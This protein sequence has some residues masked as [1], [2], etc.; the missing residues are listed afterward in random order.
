MKDNEQTYANELAQRLG[1]FK[2]AAKW[3]DFMVLLRNLD[4][5][6]KKYALP[7]VPLKKLLFKRLN[8]CLNPALP[9]GVHNKA[10]ET[11]KLI[12]ETISGEKLV[13][14]FNFLTLGLF[15]FSIHCRILVIDTFLNIVRDH[16]IPLGRRIERYCSSVL[17]GILPPLEFES[18]EYY[19]K[20]LDILAAYKAHNAP[21]VFYSSIWDVFLRDERLRI[22][23]INFILS[24]PRDDA[25]RC[26]EKLAVKALCAGLKSQDTLVVRGCLDLLAFV[27]PSK[28]HVKDE[29]PLYSLTE[30]SLKLFHKRDLSL[31]KRIYN[32]L[33]LADTFTED[34]VG[35]LSRT[36]YR[37][38]ARKSTMEIHNFFRILIT[39][40]DKGKVC[41]RIL[42]GL[43]LDALLCLEE[44]KN[45]GDLRMRQNLFG[46][47]G[48]DGIVDIDKVVE[49]FLAMDLDNIWKVFYLRLEEKIDVENRERPPDM[50]SGCEMSASHVSISLVPNEEGCAP[51]SEDKN[52]KQS[53]RKRSRQRKKRG[54]RKPK[55]QRTS[56]HSNKNM[57]A[58]KILQLIVFAVN[59]YNIADEEVFKCHLPFLTYLVLSNFRLVEE[60]VLFSFL[61]F[62]L[63]AMKF[64]EERAEFTDGLGELIDKFYA[65]ENVGI[66]AQTSPIILYAIAD[67]IGSLIKYNMEMSIP[68]IRKFIQ[69][70]GID[71]LNP[72]FIHKYYRL[73]LSQSSRTIESCLWIYQLVECN[74]LDPKKIFDVLWERFRAAGGG[75]GMEHELE[76]IEHEDEAPPE[77]EEDAKVEGRAVSVCDDREFLT[78]LLCKYNTVF[79]NSFERFML[80]KMAENQIEEICSFLLHKIS[81]SR[82]D[83]SFLELYYVVNGKLGLGDP[84][85]VKFTTSIVFLDD[86]FLFLLKKL[87]DSD[88]HANSY[89][90]INSPD[91]NKILGVLTCLENLLKLSTKF[92]MMLCESKAHVSSATFAPGM[93]LFPNQ[94]LYR[95]L[96]YLFIHRDSG[97]NKEISVHISKVLRYLVEYR[98]VDSVILNSTDLDK[99]IEVLKNDRDYA[100]IVLNVF[101]LIKA[102]GNGT[103]ISSFCTILDQQCSYYLNFLEFIYSLPDR[104]QRK[105]LLDTLYSLKN[106]SYALMITYE[107][108]DNLLLKRETGH[109]LSKLVDVGMKFIFEFFSSQFY[110]PEEASILKPE[111]NLS[112]YNESDASFIP[113]SRRSLETPAKAIGTRARRASIRMNLIKLAAAKSLARLFFSK[114]P[115]KF[116]EILLSSHP[117]SNFLEEIEFKEE[118]YI[119]ILRN[120]SSDPSK[121]FSFLGEFNRYVDKQELGSIFTKAKDIFEQIS[122]YRASSG[123]ASLQYTLPVLLA[124]DLAKTEPDLV[125]AIVSNAVYYVQKR[126]DPKYWNNESSYK[127]EIE[128]LWD[129]ISFR[130]E[131]KLLDIAPSLVGVIFTLTALKNKA[132]RKI[133]IEFLLK[134]SS[135]GLD[136]PHWKNEFMD[137]FNRADFFSYSLCEKSHLLQE[138]MV[139]DVT[140]ITSHLNNLETGFF[141]S[142]T[143]AANHKASELKRISFMVF[144]SP[145]GHFTAFAMK[146][147]EKIT[148]LISYPSLRVKREVFFLAKILFLKIPHDKLIYLYPLLFSEIGMLADKAL[149]DDLSLFSEVMKLL[150]VIFLLNT[151]QLSEIRSI[152]LDPRICTS[153]SFAERE[154]FEEVVHN[155]DCPYASG[156]RFVEHLPG[157]GAEEKNGEP[158]GAGAVNNKEHGWK[159]EAGEDG[160]EGAGVK[161]EAECGGSLRGEAERGLGAPEIEESL[162]KIELKDAEESK[163]EPAVH[164]GLNPVVT[165][166]KCDDS[167]LFKLKRCNCLHSPKEELLI[168]GVGEPY[169]RKGWQLSLFDRIAKE[170]ADK[171]GAPQKKAIPLPSKKIPLLV[172]KKIKPEEL[173]WYVL[174]ASSYYN[175][176]DENCMELDS[177]FLFHMVL[178]EFREA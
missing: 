121:A 146:I 52:S 42:D 24:M 168:E 166:E 55:P 102:T 157:R 79:N 84:I 162:E 144:S 10:L 1:A 69:Q 173:L 70:H 61:D 67:K 174:N 136:V 116:T 109:E 17:V 80:K 96:L 16:I 130:F 44:Y 131:R 28:S 56:A 86:V 178:N 77:N 60:D 175:W 46:E 93:P 137:M 104:L 82:R 164:S 153:S 68:L 126:F 25:I 145:F 122:I 73:T 100:S 72:D 110:R 119:A 139:N 81:R 40:Y 176:L 107:I 163:M 177:E 43:L 158:E 142:Q 30:Y 123:Y 14:D 117:P 133:G 38:V 106:D 34:D 58:S 91:F 94:M 132:L 20:A 8:Q 15:T 140:R 31:N 29:E 160:P 66:L 9:A 26:N 111:F 41:Q 118:L 7:D 36:L 138:I 141:V 148:G 156:E 152:F 90:F 19:A 63:G 13:S 120:Y 4:E 6:I 99:F 97:D 45:E 115:S 167:L 127:R 150:D 125:Q 33:E 2:S 124:L 65:D 71:A 105:I 50:D 48:A 101:P 103:A 159:E 35:L 154:R 5:T 37:I 95:A 57:T 161:E 147:I 47:G 114:L 49:T 53:R 89:V 170:L 113:S 3:S 151:S 108:M 27:F 64:S 78:E 51:P 11:Y 134:L 135:G 143:S 149:D 88:I 32:W 155:E 92:R 39:L 171:C 23:A 62:S 21:E 169:G 165:R 87:E 172:G 98:I 112:F 85:L 75:L 12:F 128:I 74:A 83:H 76:K 54:W 59:G 18:G 22:S 129:I